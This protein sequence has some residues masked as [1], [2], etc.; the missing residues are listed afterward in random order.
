MIKEGL[1]RRALP[2]AEKGTLGE[3]RY[4]SRQGADGVPLQRS[5]KEIFQEGR[6]NILGG[7]HEPRLREVTPDFQGGLGMKE[8]KRETF[9]SHYDP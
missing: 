9:C 4:L 1:G 8:S 6:T 3:C 7:L 5:K 2:I